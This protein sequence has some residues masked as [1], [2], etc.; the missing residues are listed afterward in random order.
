MAPVALLHHVRHSRVLH[1]R[2]LILSFVTHD[3]P[4]VPD[5]ERQ[6]V[7][8]LGQGIWRLTAAI[9]FMES[10]DVIESLKALRSR[11]L[12]IAYESCTYYLSR[13]TLDVGGPSRM[14][15]WRKRLFAFA[16]RNAQTPASYF[17]LP[18]GQVVELGARVDL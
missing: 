14:K 15:G 18:P 17:D 9:G 6:T 13:E 12:V 4:T 3:V 5:A 7:E 1:Q 10:P 11:G 2:V 16:A 8:D